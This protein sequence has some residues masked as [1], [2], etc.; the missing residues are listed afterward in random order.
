MNAAYEAL[1][2]DLATGRHSTATDLAEVMKVSTATVYN[3]IKAGDVKA[4]RV[5]RLYRVPPSEVRRLL[6]LDDGEV[7]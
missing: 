3:W 7:P 4:V 5:G 2:T 1:R 6:A